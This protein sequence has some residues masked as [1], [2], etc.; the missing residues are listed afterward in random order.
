MLL[1]PWPAVIV[2]PAGTV[3]AYITPATF[4]TLYIRPAWF[5]ETFF[6]PE[7]LEGVP[8]FATTF[9]LS[10]TL[11]PQVFTDFTVTK[12][13]LK[14]EGRVTRICN[15]PWPEVIVQLA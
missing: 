9:R 11:L 8:A 10:A 6:G 7:I 2:A 15:V 4:E 14:F 12:P 3:H 5:A 1:V 13:V